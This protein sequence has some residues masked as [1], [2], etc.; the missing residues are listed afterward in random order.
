MKA[1][2]TIVSL[3]LVVFTLIV[4]SK[5]PPL[6]IIDS[7][8][9]FTQKRIDLTKEYLLKHYDLNVSH[10]SIKPKMIVL[11]WTE[12]ANTS[13][14]FGLFDPEVLSQHS[15]VVKKASSLNVSAHFLI[16]KQGH[17]FR[18]MPETRMARHVIGLNYHA[19]GIENVGGVK[20]QGRAQ[21]DLSTAQLHA[22]IALVRHLKEKYSDIEY[23]IGHYEYQKF[24]NSPLWME[25]DKSYRTKKDD[26]NPEFVDA[27][28]QALLPLKLKRQP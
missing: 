2:L 22:N 12:D 17:I 20:K 28:H 23:L 15:D 5:K 24:E 21:A 27:V 4:M 1:F 10:I 25:K 7:P 3:T 6:L 16:D 13:K 18:L 26:P 14:C 9:S 19:I 11:H 8:I